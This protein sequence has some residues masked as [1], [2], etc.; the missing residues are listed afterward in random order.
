MQ[1]VSFSSSLNPNFA[2]RVTAIARVAVITF[3]LCRICIFF[4]ESTFIVVMR[5]TIKQLRSDIVSNVIIASIS[6]FCVFSLIMVSSC[7]NPVEYTAEAFSVSQLQNQSGYAWLKAE[8]D[9]FTPATEKVKIVNDSLSNRVS[10]VTVYVNPTCTCEGTQKTF[11]KFIKSLLSANIPD[12]L[13]TIYSMR[14]E[15]TKQPL[16][17]F[18]VSSLPTFFI[19][20]KGGLSTLQIEGK[21][22]TMRMDSLLA[23]KLTGK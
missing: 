22:A 6:L 2:T 21:N 18:T 12:S 20:R 3:Y 11:P 14:S 9:G 7:D 17:R 5:P 13:I 19:E 8:I 10:A 4:I 16:S 15:T 1:F 23:N